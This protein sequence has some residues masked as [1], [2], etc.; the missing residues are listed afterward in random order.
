MLDRVARD[1]KILSQKEWISTENAVSPHL[2]TWSNL[3]WPPEGSG[4]DGVILQ[5][6][7]Q[8]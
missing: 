2:G 8:M 7:Q 6:T 5:H 4:Q 1:E 3:C